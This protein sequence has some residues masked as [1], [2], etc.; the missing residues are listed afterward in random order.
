MRR[1]VL[2]AVTAATITAAI[3]GAGSAGGKTPKHSVTLK[4]TSKLDQASGVDNAPAGRSPGDV[5]IFTE[6]L[7][8]VHGKP[9]GSDAATCTQLFDQRM[10]CTGV[11]VLQKG[12]I[13]VQL[14]QPGPTGT[15]SQAIVGGTGAYAGASGTVHMTEVGRTTQRLDLAFAP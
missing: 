7:F 3:A 4:L 13:M 2:I 6:K 10:L 15:Y 8:D 5:L 9:A 14:I 12:Q 11:Y 1:I